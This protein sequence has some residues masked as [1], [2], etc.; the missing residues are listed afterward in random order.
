MKI[1][2]LHL[3][4]HKTG[5]TSLQLTCRENR[6]ELA[7]QGYLYPLFS[8][9]QSPKILIENHSIPL[10]SAFCSSPE[11]YSENIYSPTDDI[12][13]QNRLY[14][15]AIKENLLSSS[16]IIFSAEEASL[17]SPKELR[18][19]A[20]FLGKYGHKVHPLAV[21][22]D[23]LTYHESTVQ[24]RISDG[25]AVNIGKPASQRRGILNILTVFGT[26]AKWLSFEEACLHAGGPATFILEYIGVNTNNIRHI[27]GN[28]RMS[29]L[30][31][32]LQNIVNKLQ[33]RITQNNKLNP[34]HTRIDPLFHDRFKL[35]KE[36]LENVARRINSDRVLLRTLLD[37]QTTARDNDSARKTS[38]AFGYSNEI[39]CITILA[40]ILMCLD[41]NREARISFDDVANYISFCPSKILRQMRMTEN[42]TKTLIGALN[43]LCENRRE[44]LLSS[45][46]QILEYT[47]K[48]ICDDD[49][50]VANLLTA[51]EEYAKNKQLQSK[52]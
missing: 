41:E 12:K 25:R 28:Q 15:D 11:T 44:D 8:K 37:Q 32:R 40:A 31:T 16:K 48:E 50:L 7:A 2:F 38:A 47:I 30:S 24:Q 1:V 35:T 9:S 49:K 29:D 33:P 6:E 14:K 52:D 45:P 39:I 18:S 5:T 21:I 13:S 23:P 26:D 43:W 27:K 46:L 17:L 51:A 20:N 42:R 36:E 19:L 22:R 3:G 10:F 34:Y 4:L